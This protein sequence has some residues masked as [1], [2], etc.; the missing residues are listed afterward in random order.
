MHTLQA[1][2]RERFGRYGLYQRL[3]STLLGDLYR[4][5]SY[6]DGINLKREAEVRFYRSVLEGFRK[7][8]LIFDIGANGGDKADLFLR[9]GARVIAVEPDEKNQEIL[10][11]RFLRL[12]LIKRPVSIVGK[13]VSDS[14][15]NEVMWI[16]A[17]GSALNTLSRKWV[18][19]LR[20]DESRLGT[21]LNF[22]QKRNI[23]TTTLEDLIGS[24]GA[25]FYVKIDVEGHEVEVL[26]GLHRPI[27]YLSF[28]VNLPEFKTEGL[29]CIDRLNQI[30]ANTRFN[31]T[32]DSGSGLRLVK[33]VGR[34]EFV[35]VFNQITDPSVEVFSA[36]PPSAA[37]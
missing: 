11:Q 6:G 21:T 3:K 13:A 17:P 18:D 8:G 35:T 4:R 16:D 32:T 7:G 25:P 19:T 34:S 1:R 15:R 26:R 20:T 27:P 23:E 5:L 29:E 36:M 31:Y 10:A 12:R 24:Y 33:W 22:G 14:I 30:E 2:L 37:R 9:L 28:E